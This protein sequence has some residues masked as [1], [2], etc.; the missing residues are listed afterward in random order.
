MALARAALPPAAVEQGVPRAGAQESHG[1][2]RET[3]GRER[4][5]N[6]AASMREWKHMSAA[7]V[8]S[9]LEQSR[10]SFVTTTPRG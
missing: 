1:G 8:G 4:A 7:A 10:V 3:G 9:P 5:G 6:R 2:D